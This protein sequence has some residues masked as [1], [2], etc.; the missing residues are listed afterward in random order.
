MTKKLTTLLLIVA[1]LQLNMYS[2]LTIN[3]VLSSNATTLAD[4]EGEFDDWIEIY[5]S[6]NS[7]IDLSGYFISDDVSDL[8]AFEIPATDANKTTVPA[9]GY[10]LFWA[11]KEVE[12][13]AHHVGLKL[14]GGETVLLTQPDG[15]TIVDSLTIPTTILEDESYGSETDGAAIRKLFS[16]A[17][18][19]ESN[20]NSNDV[21]IEFSETSKLFTNSLTISLSSDG[22]NGT[23]KYTTNGNDPTSNS[24]TYTSALN[25]SSNTILKA[26][27]F[28]NNGDKSS[29]ITERYVKMTNGMA[30]A[31]SDLPIIL[32]DTYGQAL[33][34]DN[35]K[36]SFMSVIEPNNG[37][38]AYGS[39]EASFTGKAAMKIRGA[40]SATFPKKQWRVEL[41]N[42]DDS[43]RKESL[44]GM[45]ADG[46]WVLY[47]PGRYD[48][49]LINNALMYEV[50]NQ[51]GY[52]APRT[53][54]VE[55]YYNDNGGALNDSDYWGI[56]ILTEKIEVNNDRIDIAKLNPDENSGEDLT[57]GY[58]FSLDRDPTFATNY[59]TNL[60]GNWNGPAYRMRAPDT[61]YITTPQLN[62]IKNEISNFE[63]ALT[64]TNWLNDNVGYKNYTDIESW[65]GPHII[66]ALAKEPDGFFLSQYI[67]KDKNDVIKAGPIWDF[68]RAMNSPDTRSK[69]H[70]G[71]DTDYLNQPSTGNVQYWASN[72]K[73][74]AY[75]KEMVNDPCYKTLFYDK[76]FDWR[77]NN[78]LNTTQLNALIDAMAAELTESY[79]REF[80]RWNSQ[81]YTSRYGD[82]Q[83]EID[84]LKTWLKNRSEWIDNQLMKPVTLSPN[85]GSVN[86]GSTVSL[87]NPNNS[88]TIYYT[89]DGTDPKQNCSSV[90]PS[91][92]AYNSQIS[93]NTS[94]LTF[95]KARVKQGNEWGALV[96]QSFYVQ[97]DYTGLVIN[98]IHYNPQ[99]EV[100]NNDTISGTNFEFIELK[101]T[102]S[103]AINIA[104]IEFSKGVETNI[105]SKIIIEPNGFAVI[106][107]N[108]ESF[109][110]KYGF[111]PN[112]VYAGKLSD[113]GEVLI[114]NDPFG[115][116]LDEVEYDDKA[117]WDIV[118]DEGLYSLALIDA[119]T[120]NNDGINWAIQS[121][122]T[123]PKAENIFCFSADADD[124]GVC[125][126]LDQCPN[127]DDTIIGTTC[128]DGDNCTTNDVYNTACNCEGTYTDTDNDGV[129]DADDICPNDAQ[130]IC[131]LPTYCATGGN[132][133]N[134]EFIGSITVGDLTNTSG[135]NNG[136]ADFT[137]MSV[138]LTVG[139]SYNVNLVPEFQGQSYNEYW[140][141]WIDLNQDGDFEDSNETL[142]TQSGDSAVSGQISIPTNA[143]TGATKMRIAMD[144]SNSPSP[145]GNFT[146]GEVEDYLVFIV[147]SCTPGNACDDGDICTGGETFDDNCNCTGG[148]LIDS[149]NDTVCDNDDACPNGDD[150]VDT[151]NDGVPDDCDNCNTTGN[152]CDDQDACTSNDVINANC[153][154]AGNLI[155][156]DNDGV[157]DTDDICDG[158]DNADEDAD[159]IPDACDTCNN[160]LA[161]TSCNDGD[162]CTTGETYDANCNCL[163]GTLVDSDNDTVCD[164]FD[165]C[166]GDDLQD[167]DNDGTPNACDACPNDANNACGL[168]S[169]CAAQATNSTYEYIQKVSFK[170]IDNASGN[171]NGYEDFSAQSTMVAAGESVA[172]SLTPGFPG[173]AYN[174]AWTIWIDFNRDGDYQDAG[175]NIYSNSSSGN[176][177]G[178][179]TIPNLASEGATGMR[180]AMQWNNAASPCGSYQYGE[181][182]DYTIV[183]GGA[184][185]KLAKQLDNAISLYPNPAS[186]FININTDNIENINQTEPINIEVYT[187]DGKLLLQQQAAW[188]ASIQ[189]NIETLPN[190]QPYLLQIQTQ[191]S[192]TYIDKFIK[193]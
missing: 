12:Q 111:A 46:D 35:M 105:Q 192:K 23:L 45:P 64:S 36:T 84:A 120:D 93:I 49:A 29:I 184:A 6:S 40:S 100:F 113:K 119:A 169:Y 22:N 147:P 37:G 31:N 62:Y 89:L 48:R 53:R 157:C 190:N 44:L 9:N 92:I 177:S 109:Q 125:D 2:Q 96:T 126:D 144:Y 11:D 149:D 38:R 80:S 58:L 55:V 34:E 145:C 19:L 33:D 7:A 185:L 78:I 24:T 50:S 63:N 173:T 140:K 67:I 143:V 116:S 54:F 16:Q 51:L 94:G 83:G 130:D 73:A 25:I 108:A 76:W 159:N 167:D 112:A 118:A 138:S 127:E 60:Y 32:I 98:E 107:E 104:G 82:F 87:N 4:N 5:N 56:Y 183:I 164:S 141:L 81:G 69:N 88:G 172:F 131:N 10:L 122:N 171:N 70:F 90:A 129:C 158:D 182:E 85:G 146:Y 156:S 133:T 47:A 26:A 13:G 52:Y 193:L 175:E 20:A 77:S 132:N 101:N 43:D 189:L 165:I 179:V 155:D 72:Y 110:Q 153:E 14:S 121:L 188:Q 142:F 139:D 17:T 99:D 137:P 102:S 27:F 148:T 66:R 39:D 42:E 191:T 187:I 106:A 117:P 30:N 86:I 166:A 28:F 124:D 61:D 180:I 74:G 1:C 152:T 65:V 134:Y 136:Y 168:P 162:A 21:D 3:E 154:C 123:T 68:D 186:Q 59:S 95:V 128:D 18:P 97:Q 8:T 150:M 91:A 75:I 151:D 103:S 170:S 71:W 161:G 41:R 163:G 57:G 15:S 181:V 174:E 160:N 135:K 178:N 114:L 176:L 115:I 79:Q